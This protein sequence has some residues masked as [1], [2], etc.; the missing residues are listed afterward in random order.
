[1]INRRLALASAAGGLALV[2]AGGGWLRLSRQP[3]TA[4]APWTDATRPHDD[5]RLAMLSRAI[6]APNPHNRQPWLFRLTGP[7][8]VLVS[9]DL[10]RRLPETDPFDRQIT[11]GFGCMAEL[12]VIAASALG[13]AVTVRPF[14]EGVP[15]GRLDRRPVLALELGKPGTAGRDPLEAH[16]LT[17]RSTKRPFD[18]A[19]IPAAA[20]LAILVASSSSAVVTADPARVAQ[21]RDIAWRAWLVE[22]ETP[23]TF[24]ESVDLMRIGSVEI[25]RNPDGISLGG[26]LVEGLAAIGQIS[27]ESMVDP[28]S[29]GFKAGVDRY[30]TMIA[31]TPAFFWIGSGQE[32]LANA[33][34]VGRAYLRANLAATSRGLAMHPISQALQEFPEMRALRTEMATALGVRYPDM[35]ARI[36]Y[37]EPPGPS[38]RWP[39]SSRLVS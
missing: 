5:P 28:A 32:G 4:S 31:A 14:P 17:R 23:R 21:I 36:G 27:R 30:R 1:M 39:L 20:D 26:P 24:R 38:P 12:A 37:A 8:S 22:A 11:I 18:M 10:D 9:C 7:D 3:S 34:S 19:R 13:R 29:T 6:L 33:L 16:T 25:D 15:A 35:L 2:A